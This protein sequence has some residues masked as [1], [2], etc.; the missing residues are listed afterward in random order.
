MPFITEE[1]WGHLSKKVNYPNVIDSSL[2]IKTSFPEVVDSFTD[3]EIE[4]NFSLLK[5]IIVALRT[6]RSEN[7]VPPE[8]KGSAVIIPGDNTTAGL[9]IK[10]T[11]LIKMFAGLSKTTIDCKAQK[12]RFAG[13]GVIKGMQVFLELEGLIDRDIEI[14]RLDKEIDH[15]KNI[16]EKI[17]NKIENEHFITRAPEAVVKKEKEKYKGIL[18]NLE[19]LQKNL[20]ELTD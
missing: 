12:P 10:Q 15:L 20:K 18:L 17:K 13:Q 1:I 9:L 3:D 4:N 7:N 16:A 2:I 8:K 6:I 5:E 14:A 11:A 19:K